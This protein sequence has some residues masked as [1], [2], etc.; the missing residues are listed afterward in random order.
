MVSWTLQDAKNRLSAVV[1]AAL[2]G[3][4]Q[5]VTRRGGPD[6]QFER[7]PLKLRDGEW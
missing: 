2:E 3:A 7:T 5:T 1:N 6:D 4:P